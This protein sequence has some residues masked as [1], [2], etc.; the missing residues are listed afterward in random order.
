MGVEAQGFFKR[1]AE[2]IAMKKDTPYSQVAAFVRGRVRFDL[3]NMITVQNFSCSRF[4][5][6]VDELLSGNKVDVSMS[7]HHIQVLKSFIKLIN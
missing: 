2:K 7:Q 3:V 1:T 6:K 5:D 4:C